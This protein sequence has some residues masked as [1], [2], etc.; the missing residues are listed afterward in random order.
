VGT[1]LLVTAGITACPRRGTSPEASTARKQS[2]V[3]KITVFRFYPKHEGSSSLRNI[4]TIVSHQITSHITV[5]SILR[6]CHS[7]GGLVAGY[8]P[9]P[10]GF[11]PMS[12][13]VGFVV[14]KVALGQVFS[15]YFGFPC[16]FSF[17]RLLETHHVSSGVGTIGQL[18]TDVPSGLSLP[19]PQDAKKIKTEL[20][21]HR[22]GNFR[23]HT[24][25]SE[26]FSETFVS[27]G[28]SSSH[29]VTKDKN[30][31]IYCRC[32]LSFIL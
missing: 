20:L 7:S 13:H 23:S 10:P 29:H 30:L 28:H 24:L 5:S 32:N 22:R 14:D 4:S 19:S 21:A 6:P 26:N 31:H 2:F 16:Q 11:E 9:W 17:H 3:V 1:T 25:H 8:P 18:L 12:C 27:F 15:E